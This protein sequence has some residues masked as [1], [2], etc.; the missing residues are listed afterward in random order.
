MPRGHV[1]S[2]HAVH[3][4]ALVPRSLVA[5]ILVASLPAILPACGPAGRGDAGAVFS[6]MA[7]AAAGGGALRLR[8]GKGPGR[9][10]K[11]VPVDPKF[12]KKHHSATWDELKVRTE[13][14]HPKFG[15]T[16]TPSQ[17]VEPGNP[18]AMGGEAIDLA[19]GMTLGKDLPYGCAPRIPLMLLTVSNWLGGGSVP[20]SHH[21]LVER[22]NIS[23]MPPSSRG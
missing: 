6:T 11:P 23:R 21:F 20:R 19:E 13:Y 1:L 8:G 3:A 18:W 2:L 7:A 22:R 9:R 12:F 15:R 14:T 4:P 10:T 5:L 17:K 16:G